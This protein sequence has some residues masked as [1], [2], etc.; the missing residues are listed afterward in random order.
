MVT[1][2]I[3][4]VN[5]PAYTVDDSG[6]VLIALKDTANV[7]ADRTNPTKIFTVVPTAQ[8][9][10]ALNAA[11]LLA[12]EDAVDFFN[13]EAQ[14][15]AY[16]ALVVTGMSTLTIP[17]PVFS[18]D[19]STYTKST[20][21]GKTGSVIILQDTI[22]AVIIDSG[23]YQVSAL[24]MGANE[25]RFDAKSVSVRWNPA[26]G[27]TAASTAL[28]AA[29]NTLSNPTESAVITQLKTNIGTIV[30][31]ADAPAVQFVQNVRVV[32]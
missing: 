15:I 17:N 23:L 14:K 13:T 1:I 3:V 12:K 19:P 4:P 11:L 9:M 30:P 6:A 7:Y 22:T 31:H 16:R 32:T 25:S 10:A 8:T 2:N 28:I 21:V 5:T 18:G 24:V 27:S 29:Y 20:K 26:I